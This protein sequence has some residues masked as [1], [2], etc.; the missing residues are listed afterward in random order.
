MT[1]LTQVAGLFSPNSPLDNEWNNQTTSTELGWNS[2][3]YGEGNITAL[4]MS[5]YPSGFTTLE[6]IC[7]C[8]F[9]VFVMAVI[10][11]GNILVIIAIF[12]EYT[13]QNVQNWFVASL[14]LADL[15]LGVFVMPFSLAQVVMGYWIFGDLWCQ[16]HSAL[17]VLLCT[18]SI[19]NITLISLDRY[20]SITHAIEYIK[21]RSETSV[22]V[23]IC[24][25]WFLSALISVPPL[26]YPPW[27]L[28]LAPPNEEELVLSIEDQ[29][30]IESHGGAVVFSQPKCSDCA[31][32]PMGPAASSISP[33]VGTSGANPKGGKIDGTGM[34]DRASAPVPALGKH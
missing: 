2:S 11:I 25:V 29:Q 9:V 13:L 10:I 26:F 19:L 31:Q 12:S 28:P 6:V 4:Y 20:W 23:M 24:V 5:G 32:T 15:T 33:A 14:A 27:K 17:D 3:G 8:L 34:P 7:I 16:M 22:K 18:A 30:F 1:N 21:F